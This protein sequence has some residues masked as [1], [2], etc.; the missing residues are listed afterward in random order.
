MTMMLS[1]GSKLVRA[2]FRK[3][4]PPH[5]KRC[6]GAT[7]RPRPPSCVSGNAT[8]RRSGVRSLSTTTTSTRHKSSVAY[9]VVVD[10]L[11]HHHDLEVAAAVVS[12]PHEAWRVNLGRRPAD[13]TWLTG[14]RPEHWWTGCHPRVTPG[15]SVFVGVSPLGSWL[16]SLREMR[17]A[18]HGYSVEVLAAARPSS[19]HHFSSHLSVFALENYSLPPTTTTHPL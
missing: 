8:T 1:S 19:H 5:A 16:A 3:L 2:S 13:N 9:E 6:F 15:K 11:D 7:P 4:P 10:E 14:A 18:S 17:R 12:P